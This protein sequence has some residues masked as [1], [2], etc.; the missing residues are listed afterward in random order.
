MPASHLSSSSRV[1]P[2][3]VLS[4][5]LFRHAVSMESRH[6]L[7]ASSPTPRSMSVRHVLAPTVSHQSPSVIGS[8][9][10]LGTV[11]HAARSEKRS[12]NLIGTWAPY[13]FASQPSAL[14]RIARK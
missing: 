11:A 9:P 1:R 13:L 2:D 8:V 7:I 6:E 3:G 14:P 4:G 5:R 12:A 10:R